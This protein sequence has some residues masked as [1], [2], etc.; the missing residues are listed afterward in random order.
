MPS[1][2][3]I[4]PVLVGDARRCKQITDALL[5]EFGI[6]IQPT[7]YPTVPRGSER[8][9]ITCNPG[10]SDEMMDQLV[11]ALSQIWARSWSPQAAE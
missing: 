7:N 5:N 11:R 2:S 10:H 9:R 8:L 4:I 3:H 6:Y 1:A